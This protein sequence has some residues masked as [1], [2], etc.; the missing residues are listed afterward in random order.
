MAELSIPKQS[1]ISLKHSKILTGPSQIS[2]DITNRCN[3][4]C[5]HCYNRSGE[6]L[7]I[8][9]ELNDDETISFV[10]DIIKIKPFSFCFCG[11][12]PLLR[13]KILF[14][15]AKILSSNGIL[16]SVVTNGSLVTK[17]IV[18]EMIKSGI[19]G[20]QVSVD[21]STKKTHERLRCFNNSFQLAKNAI[22]LFVKSRAFNDIGIAFTPTS[23]NWN[24]LEK[25]YRLC[26]KLGITSF[27]IQ[28][29]IIQGRTLQQSKDFIPT[30]YHYRS[31]VRKINQINSEKGVQIDWGDPIDHLIRYRTICEHCVNYSHI[32]ANGDIAISPYLPI[33]LGNVK[34]YPYSKYWDYGLVRAWEIILI[35]NLSNKI[36][37]TKDFGRD[38]KNISKTWFETDMVLD[39]IENDLI[40]GGNNN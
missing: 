25:T 32:K 6:N 13:K 7:V 15:A 23:F 20:V 11:G 21:G 22:K 14:K 19:T 33:I 29:L 27:R 10:Y 40:K 35:K 39:I 1:N 38:D 9:N 5:L 26:A 18:N 4:R 28:P 12:E 2:Y 30:Q 24:E 34:K 31:I 36:K 3:F 17:K 8:K 16:V 37:S